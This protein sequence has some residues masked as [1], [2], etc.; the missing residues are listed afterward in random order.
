MSVP[1]VMIACPNLQ[2]A[3]NN[4]FLTCDSANLFD[5]APLF[6]YLNSPLNRSGYSQRVAPGNGKIR[7]VELM[8]EQR[9]EESQVT[10]PGTDY[11]C[12][13]TTKRGNLATTCTI[14]PLAYL[15]IDELIEDT[16]FSYICEANEAVIARKVQKMITAL[17]AA[18]ATR[19]TN[20]AIALIGGVSDDI[21]SGE[22][23]TVG[24]KSFFRVATA[25]SDGSV[26]P[27]GLSDLNFLMKK[28]NY[29]TGAP[30][31]GSNWYKY[32][33]L[34]QSGCCSN[35]GL[36]LGDILSRKGMAAMYDRRVNA[37]LATLAGEAGDNYA[38]MALPGALQ[39]VWYVKNDN[40]VAEG[41][42]IL[43]GT[44]YQKR[45]IF[46]PKFGFPIDLT[47]QD[48]CGAVSIIGRANPKVCALPSDLFAPNDHMNG[49]TFVNGIKIVNP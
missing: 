9:I 2:D 46:S 32:N 10:S 31:F 30:V 13:A 40:G 49:V 27:R 11:T 26:D 37:A 8:Y 22:K 23:V 14:D 20:Q 43:Q 48:N 39:I 41:A 24:G 1:S 16:D 4:N 5:S 12:T 42:G 36:D 15:Q 17:E 3:L 34:M 35:E 28:S 7:T 25:K 45:V 33:D 38:F 29:C 18:C 19:V 47:M 44:N 6:E 21:A